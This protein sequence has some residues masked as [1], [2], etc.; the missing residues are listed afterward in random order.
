LRDVADALHALSDPRI[1][2]LNGA[3]APGGVNSCDCASKN[4]P[5][6]T[7]ATTFLGYMAAAVPGVF[8]KLD[9]F[10]SHSYP[11]KGEGWGFFAPYGESMTGLTYFE[12]ELATI[13]KPNMPVLIT[14]TGWTIQ[15]EGYS[16]SRDQVA[17]FS[18][19]ALKN[20]WLTHANIVTFTPFILRDG[21]WDKFAW[22]QGSGQPYPVYTKVRA[23]RCAQAGAANCN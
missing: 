2:V 16:W 8:D 1:K 4:G 10:A 11:S 15:H 5:P 23:Y 14:E 6:G 3:L 12:K 9:A 13:G 22:V 18:V 7:L 21:N 19:D 17:D 20:V